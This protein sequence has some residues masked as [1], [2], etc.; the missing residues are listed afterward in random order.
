MQISV[1]T[2]EKCVNAILEYMKKNEPS[3]KKEIIDGALVCCGLTPQETEIITA[4]SKSGRAR[5]YIATTFNDLLAKKNI[6]RNGDGYI[7]AKEELIIVTEEQCET[8]I[9]KMLHKNS[10]SKSQIYAELD[11]HFKVKTTLS[12]KDDNMLRSIAGSVIANLLENNRIE[13]EN[14]KYQEKTQ[15]AITNTD[16]IPLPEEEFKK[17]FF[18]RLW[19][20]GGPHFESFCANVLEKYFTMTGQFVIFC[21][22][23]GGSEDGGIDI[24][25]ETL[26]HLGFYEKILVQTKCRDHAHVTEKEVR[27]FYGGVNVQGGTRGIYVTTTEF[28]QGAKKLLDSVDN[29]VGIDGEK[30]FELIKKTGYGIIKNKNGYLLDPSIFTR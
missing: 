24:V 19:L 29:C 5:S 26:D 16:A 4:N 30:L 6:I 27:E 3:T 9:L 15:V 12:N 1:K 28:H 8:Q 20:L 22:I 25:I 21:D 11:K 13:Y 10:Y 14:G 23:T 7:L 17:K 2:K 18:K